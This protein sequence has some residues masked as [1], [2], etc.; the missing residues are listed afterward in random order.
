MRTISSHFLQLIISTIMLGTLA[1]SSG[2]T[3]PTTEARTQDQG[4]I[5]VGPGG[6]II[7]GSVRAKCTEPAPEQYNDKI[8]NTLEAALKLHSIE[9]TKLKEEF[10]RNVQMLSNNTQKGADLKSI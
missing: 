6:V 4:E 2:N 1:C 5:K 8:K 3:R 7:E 9:I 10:S